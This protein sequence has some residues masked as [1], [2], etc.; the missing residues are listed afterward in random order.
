MTR[1]GSRRLWLIITAVLLVGAVF[2]SRKAGEVQAEVER[3][4]DQIRQ[5]NIERESSDRLRA[6]LERLDSITINEADATTLDVLRHLNLE[7][8]DM[9]Y[10][11]QSISSRSFDGTPLFI[12][13]FELKG[14]MT[15]GE[16]VE[17]LDEL[18]STEKMVMDQVVM[19]HGKGFGDTVNLTIKGTMYGL[20]KGNQ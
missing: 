8:S 10:R 9:D 4:N 17:R 3:K 15:Y 12:R 19:E 14:T 2:V 13:R 18:Q 20:D 7:T 11:T 6:N 1:T 5:L 16:A